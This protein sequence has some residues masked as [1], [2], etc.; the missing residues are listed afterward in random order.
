MN[1]MIIQFYK[2]FY[3]MNISTSTVIPL[4]MMTISNFY[5]FFRQLNYYY[6]HLLKQNDYEMYTFSGTTSTRKSQ[7]SFISWNEV[8]F[9]IVMNVII[10]FLYGI[11]IS[12]W[13]LE[14]I[15]SFFKNSYVGFDGRSENS[16][17]TMT[18]ML[19]EINWW[20]SFFFTCTLFSLYLS[21]VLFVFQK[22]QKVI[23]R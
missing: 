17:G 14:F 23:R 20:Q 19:K 22:K 4:T 3:L 21:F 1:A 7:T 9:S 13:I 15:F 12:K 11:P 16:E 6:S 8:L 2:F 18:M 5:P 10:Y